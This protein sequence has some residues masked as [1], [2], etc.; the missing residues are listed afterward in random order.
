MNKLIMI[1]FAALTLW[2]KADVEKI[3]DIEWHYYLFQDNGKS[4]AVITGAYSLDDEW[5]EY[6][7]MH[8]QKLC[9]EDLIIPKLLKGCPVTQISNDA[10]CGCNSLKSVKIPS[11]VSIIGCCAFSSCHNLTSVEIPTSVTMIDCDA[12]SGT[13]FWDN[14]PDGLLIFGSTLCGVKGI[15]PS[16]IIIPSYVKSIE[17]EAFSQCSWLKSIYIPSGVERIGDWAFEYCTG[18]KTLTIPESVKYYG[19]GVLNGCKNLNAIYFLCPPPTWVSAGW[20]PIDD[21]GGCCAAKNPDLNIRFSRKY[22]ASWQKIFGPI[23]INDD[24]GYVIGYVHGK[25][26]EV[27]IISTNIRT[28]SPSIMDVVYKVTSEKP[29]VKIRVLAFE[30]GERSFAKVVRPETFVDGT[31][32]N[33]GDNVTPNMEHTIS[34]RVSSDWKSKLA[35][36]KFEVLVNEDELFTREIMTIPASEQYGT[37]EITW[38]VINDSQAFDILLWLYADKDPGLVLNNGILKNVTT[39]VAN[40]TTLSVDAIRYIYSKMGYS[41]LTG[42]PLNYVNHETRLGLNPIGIQQYGYKIVDK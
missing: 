13:P 32:V 4:C 23:G 33:V 36:V 25:Q 29:T 14:Q 2:V 39:Q 35:K 1:I 11:T 27:E 24:S 9:V 26:P 40:G 22:G 28:N 12:F 17:M 7:E 41:L 5:E 42:A 38:N 19:A 18:L 10:F 30:D 8:Q 6:D 21:E 15:K 34:W 3:D 20:S 37:M 31:E 16:S